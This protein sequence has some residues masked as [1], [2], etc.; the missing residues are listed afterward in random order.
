MTDRENNRNSGTGKSRTGEFH[1][2][3]FS[4]GHKQ[5]FR[6]FCTPEPP[7]FFDR[8]SILLTTAIRL[9]GSVSAH[10]VLM[11]KIP[12]TMEMVLLLASTMSVSGD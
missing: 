9:P 5:R 2:R 1:P 12:A 11:T 4:L 10:R 6:S 7:I 3:D 8:K